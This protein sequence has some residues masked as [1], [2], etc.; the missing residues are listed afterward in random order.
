MLT[1]SRGSDRFEFDINDSGRDVVHDFEIFDSLVLAGFDYADA[2]EALLNFAQVGADAVLTK[3]DTVIV[4]HDT[5]L[6]ELRAVPATH[7]LIV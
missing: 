3:G 1:G 2:E 5:A 7:W 6:A 4:L